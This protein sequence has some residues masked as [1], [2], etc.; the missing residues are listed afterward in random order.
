MKVKNWLID[1]GINYDEK[2]NKLTLDGEDLVIMEE[3]ANE[4]GVSVERAVN[5]VFQQFIDD[6]ESVSQVMEDIK[7]GELSEEENS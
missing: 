3:I 4:K 5:L 2:T 6:P 1:M 7:N